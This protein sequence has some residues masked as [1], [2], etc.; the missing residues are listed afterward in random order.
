MKRD[1][2]S[3]KLEGNMFLASRTAWELPF[4]CRHKDAVCRIQRTA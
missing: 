2:R 4:E 3:A 1:Y